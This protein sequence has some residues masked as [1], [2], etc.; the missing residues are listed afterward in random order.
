M[1]LGNHLF[2]ARKKRGLSQEEVAGKL[3]VSR[4]TISKWETDETLP[5]IQQS[6]RLAVLYGLSLDELVEFDLDVK[7]IEEA[8]ARTS[9]KVSDKIDWTKAW[10]KKYP[11]L[12]Q[13]QKEVEIDFYASRLDELLR[14]LEKRFG[15]G[16]LNSFL[17][18]KDILATVWKRRKK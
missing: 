18:L 4:Q 10:S 17:V 12:V 7:E 15:Y 1:S 13:Y 16:E 2:E 9:E 3:G 5:D 11:I 8:I 6:K 14:D